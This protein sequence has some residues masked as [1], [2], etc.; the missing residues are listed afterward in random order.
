MI[1]SALN[2]GDDP[3]AI[4]AVDHIGVEYHKTVA[5]AK[6]VKVPLVSRLHNLA[7][8]EEPDGFYRAGGGREAQHHCAP[9][10]VI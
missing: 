5:L 2:T 10:D 9:R 7:I 1:R 3:N 6:S 8:D 4:R